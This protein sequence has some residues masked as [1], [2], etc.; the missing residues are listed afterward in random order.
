MM[1][2][3]MQAMGNQQGEAEGEGPDQNGNRSADD[4]DPLGRPRATTGPI[5]AAGSGSRRDRY[6]ACTR[7]P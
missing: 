2:Q 6:P 1:N 5:S 3:M 4:R 7:D